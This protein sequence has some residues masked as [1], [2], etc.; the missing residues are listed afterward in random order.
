MRSAFRRCVALPLLCA[1]ITACAKPDARAGASD[2]NAPA[3]VRLPPPVLPSDTA[4]PD[5]MRARTERVRSAQ[6]TLAS[7]YAV[8]GAAIVFGDPRMVAAEY[9]PDAELVT[10]DST[11]RGIVAIANSLTALGRTNSLREFIRTSVVLRFADSTVIDSGTYVALSKR[12]GAD[13]IV[14]RGRYATTW[15]V[16]PPPMQW[17][18]T[19]DRLYREARK[20]GR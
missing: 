18:I 13:S 2:P 4:R 16:H 5:T 15:R 7:N 6:L 19:R 8:L 11:Y 17:A 14:Q 9:A 20:A 1:G 3:V 10:P 12:T